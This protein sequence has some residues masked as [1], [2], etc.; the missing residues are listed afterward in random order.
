MHTHEHSYSKEIP[1]LER[2]Y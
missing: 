2:I 1:A